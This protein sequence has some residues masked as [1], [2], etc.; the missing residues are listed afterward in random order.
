VSSRIAQAAATEQLARGGSGRASRSEE[1][2]AL[3][4]D[5]NKG[6]I[7]ALY[8]RALRDQPDLQGK[9]VL[10]VHH[11]AVGRSHKNAMSSPVS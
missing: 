9:L 10:E 4:F 2:I 11:C 1:E 7:Y 6:A 8:G 5:R 3:V